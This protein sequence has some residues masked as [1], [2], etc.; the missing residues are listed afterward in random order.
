VGANDRRYPRTWLF[1]DRW[2][3]RADATTARGHQ[4]RHLTL[5]GRTT[6]WVPALQK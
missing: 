6:A 2:G 5:G 4:I 1:H 3:K